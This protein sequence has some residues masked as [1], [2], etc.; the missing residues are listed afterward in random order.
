M[1]PPRCGGDRGR[2]R[3]AALPAHGAGGPRAQTAPT[4]TTCPTRAEPPPGAGCADGLPFYTLRTHS[5]RPGAER[6][7]GAGWGAGRGGTR[8]AASRS[9]YRLVYLA[10]KSRRA[11]TRRPGGQ[12]P[13]PPL[14]AADAFRGGGGRGLRGGRADRRA[15]LRAAAG[16]CVVRHARRTLMRL[17]GRT[18]TASAAAGEGRAAR[19]SSSGGGV[20]AP[21]VGRKEARDGRDGD[22]LRGVRR[23][24]A[25]AAA[26]AAGRAGDGVRAGGVRRAGTGARRAAG[27]LP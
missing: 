18:G 19:A 1:P 6:V 9:P 27:A 8:L 11:G 26:V 7:G 21:L 25:R 16:G 10:R 22:S 13:S 5:A 2:D 20:G 17:G 14:G 15:P 23:R 24:V 3:G 12:P 4:V